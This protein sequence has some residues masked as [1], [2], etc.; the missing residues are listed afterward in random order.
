M[1]NSFDF[2]SDFFRSWT[3]EKR[4]EEQAKLRAAAANLRAC[5][6]LLGGRNRSMAREAERSA[7]EIDGMIR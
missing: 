6:S 1:R 2:V 3:Y 7:R 5:A 4:K